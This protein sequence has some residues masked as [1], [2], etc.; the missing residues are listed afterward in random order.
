MP[1]YVLNFPTKDHWRSVAKLADII[2]GLEYLLKNYKE[3]GITSLAVP[4][5]GCGEGQLE[6]WIVGPTLYRYLKRMDIQ[7]TLY[8]PYG[9][10]HEELKPEFLNEVPHTAG[11]RQSISESR[12]QPGLI[13]LV[14]ILR[15]IEEQP[16]H[17]PVGRTIFQKIAYVA[18]EEGLPTGLQH[19]RSSFGPFARELKTITSRL[20]N[21]GLI[22]ENRQ[23]NMFE[24]KV[25]PTFDD[26]RKVYAENLNQWEPIIEK[27][28][29][30][31]MR[32]NTHQAEIVATVLFAA[33]SLERGRGSGKSKKSIFCPHNIKC[34][35]ICE[36]LNID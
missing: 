19:E 12:V 24:V 27:V 3:W 11:P 10:P 18:T 7:V 6:W 33:R 36:Y 22:S 26:A 16:Y 30:L 31:F 8:A 29:D 23:G 4:P 17:W 35:Q 34:W 15:R 21:N 14:E 1:P 9:T 25:G 13:G 5:L 28:V 2:R 32:M 20:I